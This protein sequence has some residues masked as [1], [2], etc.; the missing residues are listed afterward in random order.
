MIGGRK[1]NG[2][3]QTSKSF[4]QG[5]L[6]PLTLINAMP[7]RGRIACGPILPGPEKVCAP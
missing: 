2:G 6:R 7:T 3:A 5:G 4:N 1:Q